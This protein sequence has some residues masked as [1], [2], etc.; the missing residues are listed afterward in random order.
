MERKKQTAW[1]RKLTVTAILATMATASVQSPLLTVYAEDNNGKADDFA[2]QIAGD[3]AQPEMKYR[4]YARWW[5]AEGSH[6]D[7]TLKESVQELYDDGYGGIEFVTLDESQYLDN[8]TYAWGSPEWIHDTKVIIE[9]CNR[10]GMSVSMTSGTHWSTANLVSITPDEEAASQELGYTVL[11]VTGSADESGTNDSESTGG[12]TTYDGYL[13]YC[14][15]PAN[16][17]KQTLVKVIAAKVTERGSAPEE[18]NVV[19]SKIDISSLKDVT[20]MASDD[21]GDGIYGIHFTAEDDGDYDLFAFYQYGT[22]ESYKPAISPSYTINYLDQ[23]GANA[24]IDYW[25]SNVLTDDVQ[26]L[27]NGIDECDMYMDS[28]ELSTHGT[29]TTGQ[30]WCKD[31]EEQFEKRQG[32]SMEEM[33]PLLVL[34]SGRS[35]CFGEPLAYRY[36]PD[37]EEDVQYV[38][39]L[40]RDFCQTQTELYTENCMNVLSDWLHSKNMKLRA[41]N[42]YGMRFEISEPAVAL[43]YIE[44]ESMEFANE[45]DSHRGMAGAA[46]LLNKRMSSETGAWVSKN[47]VYNNEYYRQIFYMQYAAGIQ[48]TVTHGYSSEYGPEDRVKW[49]GYEGMSD[50]WSDRFNKRQPASQD[51]PELNA[52]LSRIQKALEQGVPQM[53]LAILRTDYAYNNQLTPGGLMAFV[54][55]G[56][57][58]NKAHNQD[59]YYWRDMELQNAG[60]TYDYFSPYLLTNENVTSADGLLNP[61]GAAYQAVILMEDE[62]P[63]EAA[64]KLLQWA[65]DGLPIVFVNNASEIVANNDVTKDNTVAGGTTGSNDGNEEAL[66]EIVKEMKTLSNVKTV[67]VESDAYEALQELG[68][69]PRVQYKEANTKL[70]PVMRSAEDVDYL[71]LYHY[72]YEDEEKYEG[73]VSLEGIYEP[74]ILDT[75]SGNVDKLQNVSYESG[76]TVI[77]VDLAPGETMML[78]L[79]HSEGERENAAEAKEKTE[80]SPAEEITE[81]TEENITEDTTVSEETEENSE[82]KLP[83]DGVENVLNLTDWTLV[84]DSYEPGEKIT[85]TEENEDTGVTTTE[86]TYT[87]NHVEID[88]GTLSELISW[89]DIDK[90]GEKVSGTGTYTTTFTLPENWSDTGKIQFQADS[91]QGGTA[92]VWIND[93]KVPVNMDRRTADLTSYVQ[94]GENTITVRVTSSLRNVM[95]V[96]GYEAGW[97]FGAPEPDDY[98]MTGETK[99]LYTE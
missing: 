39:N 88:A 48:K 74:Y 63:Y 25:N 28:L 38:E 12:K 53:D 69:Y 49:P 59:A 51:Y 4:P 90:I 50:E 61:D 15:L 72:M 66:A 19:P 24:L 8:E 27:I 76:R 40:R 7:E 57:Y 99:L 83:Q 56:V 44:T 91:F 6:T 58:S 17:T 77:H 75:W 92:A 68:V 22:G 67:E 70:L 52:H 85:R 35:G 2:A 26:E 89:R 47:Y 86:A 65:K 1:K 36:E 13:P 3:Y 5:L 73:D 82:Q 94:P 37:K 97:V 80:E 11:S 42:S 62:L 87:T 33:L 34:T 10:L 16:V 31:M 95:I 71:Y 60:Y 84:V 79:K 23:E 41:E 46:H 32:Y 81:N 14:K 54:Q 96:Q 45:L 93:T 29:N 98:G 55:N 9:E 64:E 20:D 18:K 21:N 78:A 43:D 30:L